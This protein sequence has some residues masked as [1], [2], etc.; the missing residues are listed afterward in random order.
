MS[1]FQWYTHH[2][3]MLLSYL[4]KCI[5]HLNI[6]LHF[7]GMFI[8]LTYFSDHFQLLGQIYSLPEYISL[9]QWYIHHLS[10]L[11][12]LSFKYL[13]KYIRDLNIFL[14]FKSVFLEYASQI[15]FSITWLNIFVT[16]IYFSN[17]KVCSFVVA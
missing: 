7:N 9:F 8:T 10:I 11:L 16:R 2:L 6:F 4:V 13:V 3:S 14:H 15:S 1:P 5:H 17:S 12:S